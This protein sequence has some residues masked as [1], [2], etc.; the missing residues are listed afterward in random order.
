MD[1]FLRDFIVKKWKIGSFTF[2][3]LDAL[4]AVCITGTGIFLRLPV[5]DYT[6]TGPEKI[7]AIVLEYLLAVLCGAIVHRCTGSRNRAFLT[8]AI[9]VIYPTIAANGA[10]WTV[11]AVYYGMLFFAGFYLYIRGFRVLGWISGLAGT[12]IALY[13]IWQWQMALSVAYPVSLSRGWPNFYEIIGKTAF[14]DLFD[15]VSLLVLAG[16]LLTL[17]YCFAKKKVRITPDLALQLFLFLAVLIPYFAPYMPAWA[18]YTADIAALLYF[19]RRKERFYLPMLHLIVSYS[20]YAYMTNGETKLPMVVFSVILLGIL[21][22]VGVDLYREAAA[23]AAPAAA[24]LTGTEQAD[25]ASVREAEAQGAK[26]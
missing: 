16:L 8:Y 23:Q 3:F 18:G 6:A 9:L 2:T 19:M 22:N 17:A 26:S 4:L 24:G 13:R 14:V 20:A 15:K 25:E 11:N 1:D 12:A 7:G 10:L 5:M 21:V